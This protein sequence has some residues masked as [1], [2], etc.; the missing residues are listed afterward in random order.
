M[1]KLMAR[2]DRLER[3]RPPTAVCPEHAT[4]TPHLDYRAGLRPFLPPDMQAEVPE[5]EVP[6]PCARCGWQWKPALEVRA[7]EDWG[8]R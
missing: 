7:H 8:P 6:P 1:G 2:L 4:V 3:R 5:P